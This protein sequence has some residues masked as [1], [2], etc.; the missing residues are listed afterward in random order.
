MSPDSEPE[1]VVEA[2][3]RNAENACESNSFYLD[4]YVDESSLGVMI[5]GLL[6]GSGALPCVVRGTLNKVIPI[7]NSTYPTYSTT[8]KCPNEPLSRVFESCVR[9]PNF[10]SSEESS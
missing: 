1:E 8:S 2:H 7:S 10:L 6:V 5:Q 3:L 9:L 4:M